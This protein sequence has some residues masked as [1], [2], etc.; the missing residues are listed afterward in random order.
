MLP[1]NVTDLND[2][3][4]DLILAAETIQKVKTY[5][6]EEIASVKRQHRKL[7]NEYK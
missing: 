7:F 5:T 3:Q 4:D 6:H 2:Q 1:Q